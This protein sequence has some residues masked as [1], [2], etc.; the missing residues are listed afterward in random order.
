MTVTNVGL[1][2]A[3]NSAVQGLQK[4][5]REIAEVAQDVAEN[6]VEGLEQNIVDLQVS[7]IAFKANLAVIRTVDE[8]TGELLDILA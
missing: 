1:N 6:G 5:S 2:G 3:L 4:A 8:T 7:K